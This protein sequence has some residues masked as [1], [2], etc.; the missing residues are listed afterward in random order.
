MPPLSRE[1]RRRQP[2]LV[3]RR[4]CAG[5]AHLD[6][7]ERARACIV[8]VPPNWGRGRARRLGPVY[9]EQFRPAPGTCE[10]G[11]DRLMAVT[12]SGAVVRAFMR[13]RAVLARETDKP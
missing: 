3:P 13:T 5:G 10:P 2:H 7:G 12:P 6:V 9:S 8:L 1:R 4:G 11:D